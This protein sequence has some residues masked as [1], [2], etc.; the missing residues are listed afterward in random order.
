MFSSSTPVR[1][2]AGVLQVCS[3]GAL[4]G[5]APVAFAAVGD[6]PPLAVSMW[7]I[8][9]AAVVLGMFA[10]ATGV[11][12]AVLAAVRTSPVPVV[13]IGLG[14]AAYQALW[15]A[16]IPLAGA[17]VST[18]V[19]ISLAPVAVTAWEALRTRRTP[20]PGGLATIAVA[21]AGLV[22]VS[23]VDARTGTAPTAGVLLAITSGLTYA[24]VTV[25][26]RH[27][28]PR[29]APLALTT[30]TT[31]VG[32]L[33]LLPLA[34]LTGPVMTSAPDS[35]LAL[36][37]LGVVT[38]AG[39]YLLL[40]AGLRTASAGTAAVATLLEPATAAVLAVLL[41]GESLPAHGVAGVVLILGA[42]TA[43]RN[44]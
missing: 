7:R 29:I 11:T 41:L 10:V 39:G 22:L 34:V 16:S 5:T 2:R 32:A 25:V 3:A 42:V 30:A 37:Y 43:L 9:V 36:G 28:A 20:S 17:A 31:T 19:A 21:L 40:Y 44:R 15:F 4:W 12:T 27:A 38:M 6:L 23:T 8:A 14:V 33:G 13:V 24:A 1:S 18:V 35:L 26:G